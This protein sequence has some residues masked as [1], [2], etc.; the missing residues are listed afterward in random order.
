VP[1]GKSG[2][3]RA[4]QKVGA[5]IISWG[6]A[7]GGIEGEIEKVLGEAGEPETDL[8]SIIH[9]HGLRTEFPP[10]VLREAEEA[11]AR[12]GRD[13]CRGRE[14][15]RGSLTFTIDPADAKDFDDAVSLERRRDGW[16]LGVHIADV[17]HFVRP[18]SALDREARERATSVYFPRT[19][20][21][22]LPEA[23]SNGVCS[24]KEG[25]DRLT[26]SVFIALSGDGR[27]GET[28]FASTV[29]RSRKRFTYERVQ[30]LLTGAAAPDGGAERAILPVLKEMERLAL[31]LRKKRFARGA[32]DL[33][34]PETV[35]EFDRRGRVTGVRRAEFDNSHILIEEFM[36]A[37]NEAV[38]ACFT[39]RRAPALWRV[40]DVP[41]DEDLR[42][43]GE[44]VRPFGYAIRALPDKKALQAFL[45]TVSGRPEA[46]ALHLAFLRSLK[47]ACY[48]TRNIGHYGLGARHYH[49]FTSPIRRYP[50]LVTHRFLRRLAAGQR[51]EAPD[52]FEDLARHCS[53]AEERAEDAE[54]ECLTLA[55]LRYLKS[56]LEGG[57]VDVLEGVITEIREFGFS[58]YLNDYLLAGFVHVNS[59]TDDYYRRSRDRSSLTG[60]RTRRRFRVGDVVRVQVARVNLERREVDF[61]PAD[62]AARER[63]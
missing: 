53:E 37:A 38:G 47:L 11:A 32:L 39:A 23:L 44:L 62:E 2:G 49:Y 27:P 56:H 17:S 26:Q 43:F 19:V 61:V 12:F 5:R 7:R 59:L 57:K 34:M 55:K 18:G 54:R 60:Q 22:M 35:L 3:A 9:S 63:R 14:D 29:I 31:L 4:G 20:L 51:V 28:R 13:A 46:Y 1:P 6:D 21:P 41:D 25:E 42:E 58:A 36:L 33:D 8:L 10:A 16:V 45:D 48:S 30:S 52:D 24:L 40:H 50:D 15:L